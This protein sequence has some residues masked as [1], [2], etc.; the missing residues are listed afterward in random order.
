MSFSGSQKLYWRKASRKKTSW[1]NIGNN[2]NNF[3][4]QVQVNLAFTKYWRTAS[5][6]LIKSNLLKKSST[7]LKK[8]S[9]RK[10]KKT[11]NSKKIFCLPNLFL[12]KV[13]W[14]SSK[15]WDSQLNCQLKLLDSAK[16]TLLKLRSIWLLTNTVMN[17]LS[18]NWTTKNGPVKFVPLLM[19]ELL[20]FARSAKHPNLLR[21]K[22]F[23]RK[24]K[25]KM[26]RR[27]NKCKSFK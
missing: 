17:K 27:K 4:V 18:R 10:N 5:S 1:T 21:L 16:M 8:S 24:L 12:T 11:K 9:R 22:K 2:W 14:A 15:W 26:S 3:K 6:M 20:Q 25:R 23:R 7:K 19:K 13:Y